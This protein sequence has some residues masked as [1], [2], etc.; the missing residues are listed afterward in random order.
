M[1]NV[2]EPVGP[3][4]AIMNDV[5]KRKRGRPRKQPQETSDPLPPKKPRGR[6]RGSKKLSAGNGQML[7][8]SVEKRPRGRPRK[9]LVVQ[10]EEHREDRGD[11]SCNVC[12]AN[13]G[14][15]GKGCHRTK[16]ND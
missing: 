7:H 8:A 9:W 13:E 12:P 10:E 6:P 16:T 11:P 14:T 5:P 15:S 3:E 1:S 4:P 2:G